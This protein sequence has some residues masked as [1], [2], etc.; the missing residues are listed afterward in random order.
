MRYG[1]LRLPVPNELSPT[2]KEWR[3]AS[4][5]RTTPPVS[6]HRFPAPSHLPLPYTLQVHFLAFTA[7][8]RSLGPSLHQSPPFSL[9]ELLIGRDG[10]P[11]QALAASARIRSP[12]R[13][14]IQ[15][16]FRERVDFAA[17]VAAT[18]EAQQ[19]QITL[20]LDI[21]DVLGTATVPESLLGGQALLLQ[22]Q[23]GTLAC[24]A[25]SASASSFTPL[26][27]VGPISPTPL[28]FPSNA[29]APTTLLPASPP[30]NSSR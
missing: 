23:S 14:K 8:H 13:L 12:P 28:A 3:A 4:Q 17:A 26:T 6:N 5:L 21:H 18:P 9:I 30:R 19:L 22:V 1:V 20:Q 2:A 25:V 15:K 11:P 27:V 24:E 29:P 7:W 16:I 10:D